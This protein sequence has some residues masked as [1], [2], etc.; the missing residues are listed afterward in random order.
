MI[1]KEELK[2]LGIFYV[3]IEL[4]EVEIL[5]DITTEQIAK[6]RVELSKSGLELLEDKKGFLIDKIKNTIMEMIHET[7]EIPKVEH[8][9]YIS[10]KLGL[11]YKEIASIFSEVKGIAIEQFIIQ[12]KIEKA[13]ELILYQELN[14]KEITGKLK[15]TNVV[16]LANQFKKVTGLNPSYYKKLKH[17]R[18]ELIKSCDLCND[19]AEL[20]KLN[21]LQ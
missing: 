11:D 19:L 17:H 18:K 13:K 1:V 9:A 10:E 2:K 20:D 21:K 15:Y 14:L 7:D 5:E 6:L 8:S 16:H 4:G 3:V 12:H